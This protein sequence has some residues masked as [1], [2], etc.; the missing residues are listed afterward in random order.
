[1]GAAVVVLSGV[2]AAGAIGADSAGDV[3]AG[4]AVVTSDAGDAT[5]VSL[6]TAG[7]GGGT[8]EVVSGSEVV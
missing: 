3:S 2:K 4:R 8:V 7:D 6:G 5:V 1:M